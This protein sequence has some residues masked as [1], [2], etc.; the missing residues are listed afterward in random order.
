LVKAQ[1]E[2]LRAGDVGEV[3]VLQTQVEEQLFQN[4]LLAA[5]ADAENASLALS[6]FLG[7]DRGQTLLVP[8]G[9]LGLSARDFDLH[10]LLA[11]ALRRRPDLIALRHARDSA[12]TGVRLEKANRVPDVDVGAGWTRATRSDNAIAPSP[13][14][15]SLGLS[16][17][18]PIPLWN[19][20]KAAI[21]AA[22][23][24]AE[25]AEK[26]LESAE[27]KAEVQVRQAFTTYRSA[28]ERLSRYKGTILKDAEAVLEA[29]RFSYQRGQTTLLDLLDAQRT[30]N[31]VRASYNDA[32]ADHAKALIE[33]QRSAELWDLQF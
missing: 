4:E 7:R 9:N 21:A 11:G 26:Q 23:F 29:K 17:S 2:R 31:E 25:Q 5:Q 32:L 6:G 14:F 8:Q 27:L 12:Q 10:S 19:R 18:V 28:V 30:A 16:F 13:E 22:R 24:T 20:N 1:R 3:D 33:L 15:D